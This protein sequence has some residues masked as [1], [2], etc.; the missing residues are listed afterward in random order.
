MK[1]RVLCAAAVG[2]LMLGGLVQAQDLNF[3]LINRTDDAVVGF[4]VSHTGTSEWEENLIPEGSYL[5][6]GYEVDVIIADGLATCD[7]DILVEFDNGEEL[8]DYNLDLCELGSYTVHY[9]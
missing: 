5:A 4:Y 6:G 3:K 1:H 7:Y 8:E 9:E 2:L